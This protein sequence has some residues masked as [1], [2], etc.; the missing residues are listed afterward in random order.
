MLEWFG[1]AADKTKLE[2]LQWQNELERATHYYSG[3][4]TGPGS[5]QCEQCGHKLQFH[6][7]AL[8][9]ACPSCGSESYTRLDEVSG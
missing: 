6:E 1:Q 2:L 3:E 5:L 4:V 9:P 7:P 8:I